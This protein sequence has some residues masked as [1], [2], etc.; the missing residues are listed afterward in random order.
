MLRMNNPKTKRI[1][2]LIG[3]SLGLS[4]GGIAYS[5]ISTALASIGHDLGASITELQWIMNIFGISICSSLVIAGRIADMY[6]RKRLYLLG[7]FG[8][9]VSMLCS[10]FASNIIWIFIGQILFG[11]SAAIILPVSQVLLC[12]A[13]PKEDRGK[14]IGLWAGIS[15]VALAIGPLLSGF[16]ITALSWRWVF[17]INIPVSIFSAIFT[18][19]YVSESRKANDTESI[20]WLG[21]FFLALTV[22]FFVLG[23]TQT[24]SWPYGIVASIYATSLASFFA[25]WAVER[26]AKHPIIRS[27][28]FKNRLFL[29]ASAAN[30]CII[31]FIW[32]IFFLM[33]LYL[34][35]AR[36][37]SVL[38]TGL[39][40]LFFTIP[41]SIFSL[42]GG[43]LYNQHGGRPLIIL[44]FLFF[45]ASTLIQI[46]FNAHTPTLVI[47]L[48]A[49]LLGIGWG[50]S[51]GPT[52]TDAIC[53]LA[54]E[55]AGIASGSFITIQETGGG[56]GLAI[57]VVVVN[58]ESN[59]VT[60]YQHG[61]W[62]LFFI[63]VIGLIL[64]I[65]MR[66]K[67]RK[68]LS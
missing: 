58:S 22:G 48:G 38:Q 9:M 52:T 18:V 35:N 16:V 8:M 29:T 37:Y 41:L 64:A 57:T 50:L 21:S 5:T 23:I 30:F 26:K 61:M 4:I 1:L 63:S 43:K 2:A 62:L 60:G 68:F 17:L 42:I 44:G 14:A 47:E 31:F 56:L 11:L 39:I 45:I 49:L 10:G 19:L 46:N 51:W 27:D 65:S 7:I 13:V 28:L 25:L 54:P 36:H 24:S 15:G 20:D 53:T 55:D 32:A 12:N 33:P 40:M 34:Q 66:K 6:G 59:F 3:V 67:D